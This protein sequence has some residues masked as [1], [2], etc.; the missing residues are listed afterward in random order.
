MGCKY[1]A[2]LGFYKTKEILHETNELKF[3]QRQEFNFH[4]LNYFSNEKSTPSKKCKKPNNIESGIRNSPSPEKPKSPGSRKT[5]SSGGSIKIRTGKKQKKCIEEIDLC[6]YSI[7][8]LLAYIPEVLSD[9]RGILESW[10]EMVYVNIIKETGEISTEI[11]ISSTGQYTKLSHELNGFSD[12][13]VVFQ[14]CEQHQLTL[15]PE[16]IC[17]MLNLIHKTCLLTLII[18]IRIKLLYNS[19]DSCCGFEPSIFISTLQPVKR[20]ILDEF[21]NFTPDREIVINWMH[22]YSAIPLQLVFNIT[23]PNWEVGCSFYIFEG[24]EQENISKALGLFDSFNIDLD[25]KLFKL[26]KKVPAS[27]LR[28]YFWINNFGIFGLEILIFQL[29]E[30]MELDICKNLGTYFDSQSWKLFKGIFGSTQD[31]GHM[32]YSL[33]YSNLGFIFNIKSEIY[34]D[35]PNSIEIE[36]IEGEEYYDEEV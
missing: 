33:K 5:P 8:E 20:E 13:E 11:E 25:S 9:I 21:L 22:Q 26:I 23:S 1:S 2:S 18:S 34:S 12:L 27:E 7:E 10:K 14:F 17:M 19:S 31:Q 16:Y 35:A 3:S 15:D 30:M 32:T 28:A 36:Q 4:E 6:I 29:H 24:D